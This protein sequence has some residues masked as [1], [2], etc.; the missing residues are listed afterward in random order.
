MSGDRTSYRFLAA[1]RWLAF[2]VLVVLLVIL[3]VNLGFWQLRRYQTKH[4]ANLRVQERATVPAVDPRA[5]AGA[6]VAGP[7]GTEWR[8]VLARGRYDADAQVAVRNRS[9]QGTGGLHLV[10]PLVLDDGTAVLV[11]RGW[12]PV[13]SAGAPPVPPDGEVTVQGRVRGTQERGDI[14]PR[15]PAEGTLTQM[16][17]VDVA[18]IQQQVPYPLLPFY[19][20]LAGQEPPPVGRFPLVLPDPA[21]D[22]GPHLS[23]MAQWWIFSVCAVAGWVVVVRKSARARARTPGAGAGG[24][25]APTPHHEVDLAATPPAGPGRNPGR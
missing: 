4:E 24:P 16:A 13:E 10:T 6:P 14:G 17:R 21:F 2:H 18:R 7:D 1:P 19:V 5:L 15:D 23:Y 12:I 11:N 3:M 25:P 20:E 9:F 8:I 22:D